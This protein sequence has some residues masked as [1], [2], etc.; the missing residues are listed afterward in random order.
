MKKLTRQN[1]IYILIALVIVIVAF[2]GISFAIFTNSTSQTTTNT[3]SAL[4]CVNV[5][6]TGNTDS[7]NLT[8]MYPMTDNEGMETSPYNFTVTNAC[9]NYVEY[10]LIAS[11]IS[12]A[13]QLNSSYVKAELDGELNLTPKVITSLE[14]Y[15][16]PDS[17]S[18]YTILNN[19]VL[20][21][22]SLEANESQT[23][24]YRMWVDGTNSSVW[25]DESVESKTFQVKLS[26][27][28]VVKTSKTHLL[29]KLPSNPIGNYSTTFTGAT[30]NDKKAQL[31]VGSVSSS[32]IN[33]INLTN[34]D[35]SAAVNLASK[36][37]GL[38]GSTQGDGQVVNENGYRY[39][40]FNPNNYISFNGELWRIIGVF[41]SA[42]HGVA[43]TN[44]VKIIRNDSLGGLAWDKNNTNDWPDSSL[45]HLLNDYYYNGTNESTITY[46]YGYSTSVK[47]NCDFTTSGITN[48]AYRNMIQNVTWYLGGMASATTAS[49]VYTAERGTT[50]YTG[51]STSSVGNIGLMYA[52]DYGYASLA[53]SCARTT[54]V[55]SYSS[56]GC[57][58]SNWLYGQGYEWIIVPSSSNADLVW[59]LN[60]YGSVNY[61]SASFGFV[62]R[63][64][65]YLKSDVMT[66]A[67]DGSKTNPY[68]IVE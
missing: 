50:V 17:L 63:P 54:N 24:N 6:F 35:T 4:D 23:M 8:N 26:V 40:G 38:A 60:S 30:W 48:V 55:S 33:T 34:V 59:Y 68:V 13:S 51:R 45:Y 11:V 20:A 46:C 67:G 22:S 2:G 49:T 3:M 57:A 18:S 44:L 64:T 27:V 42:S 21:K 14:T 43:N 65:L 16:T 58:G 31:E 39:E 7:V 53:S 37:I 19:Y 25:T 28:G 5:T 29:I 9:A 41:D 52:S 15:P 1:I 56:S 62:A 47:A 66:Y 36:I 61:N 32:G 10:Y 12:N